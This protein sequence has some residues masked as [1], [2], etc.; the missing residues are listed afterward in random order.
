VSSLSE[1]K[2]NALGLCVS[3]ATAL[4]AEAPWRFL[5]LDD[6][7]QSWDDQHEIQFIDIVRALAEDEGRQIVLLSHRDA[8][9]EQVAAQCRSVN[10]K[11]F[12][13]SGYTK[14]GPFIQNPSWTT[15][16]QRL[17][18]VLA[19]ASDPAASTVRLQQ[20]EEEIRI[21]TC[22]IVSRVS[23]IILKTETN[24][25]KMNSEAAR[26]ILNQAGYEPRL[27]D[28]V[29]GAFKTTDPAHHPSKIFE[30]SAQRVLQYHGS[31]TELNRWLGTKQKPELLQ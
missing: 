23:Q 2:L 1:S 22:D 21:A 25:S 17:R 7:I 19:I 20:A 26:N 3:I 24:A 12:R 13:I 16:E 18:E 9:I 29:I 6:P 28:K 30:P 31:L 11:R 15:I 10:G 5:V 4:R 14:D 27:I 8:W